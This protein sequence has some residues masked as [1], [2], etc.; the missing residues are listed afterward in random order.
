MMKVVHRFVFL[1]VFALMV[2]I[3]LSL[4][5]LAASSQ[6]WSALGDFLPGSRLTGASIGVGLFSLASI[7]F[8]TGLK[9]RNNDRFLSFSNDEGAVN[10]STDAIAEYISKLAPEFP[11]VVK[12][13]PSVIPHRSVIDILIDVR[14]KAGPQLHEICEVLQKRVRESMN[15]GLGI[16]DVRKVIIRVKKISIEHKTS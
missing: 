4:I 13:T 15:K 14:I 9:P 10:I 6:N 2:A 7:L 12:M 8:L 5:L 16:A 11:S 1:F 3:G